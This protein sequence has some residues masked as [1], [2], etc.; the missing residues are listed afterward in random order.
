MSDW[1]GEAAERYRWTRGTCCDDAS[2][3]RVPP[4]LPCS[5]QAALG[6]PALQSHRGLWAALIG[7]CPPLSAPEC[8]WRSGVW[9]FQR[10][11]KPSLLCFLGVAPSSPALAE[12]AVCSLHR[13]T[14]A[15]PPL[16]GPPPCR[17]L[18][19]IANLQPSASLTCGRQSKRGR[20]FEQI[21]TYI[22]MTLPAS[23]A[24]DR[25][26]DQLIDER[27]GPNTSTNR[28]LSTCPP[29][30]SPL[31]STPFSTRQLISVSLFYSFPSCSLSLSSFFFFPP[32]LKQ[33][34]ILSPL[35]RPH[36]RLFLCFVFLW[37]RYSLFWFSVILY[38]HHLY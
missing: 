17:Y 4:H 38:Y 14:R 2:T 30:S 26:M 16:V 1:P 36:A 10:V 32:I 15:D 28:Q 13:P 23:A 7:G 33:Q 21:T 9:A 31:P 5:W 6:T 3:P 35:S 22:G 11:E 29:A 8:A 12:V 20:P 18:D 37:D 24:M 34:L 25:S 19:T 27:D